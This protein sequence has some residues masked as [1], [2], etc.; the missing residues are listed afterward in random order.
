MITVVLPYINNARE[1][2]ERLGHLIEKYGTGQSNGIAFSDNNEVWYLETAGGH[3]WVAVRIPDEC[4]AI[5]PNQINIQKI[6]FNDPD[7]FMYSSNLKRFVDKHH[8][9]NRPGTFNF[10]NIAGTHT[11][12]D[13]HYN[14]PQAW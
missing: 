1:G 4:Y 7:H 2:V 14:T 9:N 3:H 8:L 11:K 13:S 6:D 10:R 5:A 12:Q